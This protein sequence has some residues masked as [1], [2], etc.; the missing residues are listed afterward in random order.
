M[1]LVGISLLKVGSGHMAQD[2]LRS[3]HA[4]T[5]HLCFL[6][7]QEKYQQRLAELELLDKLQEAEHHHQQ[8]QQQHSNAAPAPSSSSSSGGWFSKMLGGITGSSTAP[9]KQLTPQ[10]KARKAAAARQ[11]RARQDVGS[12]P[13]APAAPQGLYVYGSVGSGK[14]LLMD[15]FYDTARQELQLDHSRR[16]GLCD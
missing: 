6:P 11:A 8:Q 4:P 5:H 10:Q 9:E 15:L 1:W 7:M 16:C 12:P 14:S 13:A 2:H 3:S